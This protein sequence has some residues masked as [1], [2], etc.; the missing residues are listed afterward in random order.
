MSLVN[1]V[2]IAELQDQYLRDLIFVKK[3]MVF[4]YFKVYVNFVIIVS[5]INPFAPEPPLLG[6]FGSLK[7]DIHHQNSLT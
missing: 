5:Y 7:P 4:I 2:I 6:S 3:K 1:A